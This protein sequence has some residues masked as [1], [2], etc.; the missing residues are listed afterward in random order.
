MHPCTV[1]QHAKIN[2]INAALDA[3]R[4]PNLVRAQYRLEPQMLAY[5]LAHRAVQ[6]TDSS[7]PSLERPM[8]PAPMMPESFPG[9]PWG[10]SSDGAPEAHALNHL[11][12][13]PRMIDSSDHQGFDATADRNHLLDKS[14]WMVPLDACQVDHDDLLRDISRVVESPWRPFCAILDLLMQA[15][16]HAQGDP[17]LLARMRD[18]VQEKLSA[19]FLGEE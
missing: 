16:R 13:A 2:A 6:Q 9:E 14:S 12:V 7:Q 17:H 15:I 5:H 18:R 1:C 19:A 3:G 10:P 11:P 8:I 4:S